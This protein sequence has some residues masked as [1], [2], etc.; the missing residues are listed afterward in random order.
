MSRT[1]NGPWKRLYLT[2]LEKTGQYIIEG[3]NGQI[4]GGDE[5]MNAGM[6]IADADLCADGGDYSSAVFYLRQI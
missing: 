5:L 1:P 6:V 4:F 3:R 2:G